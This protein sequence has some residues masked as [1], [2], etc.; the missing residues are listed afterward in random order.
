MTTVSTKNFNGIPLL[1]PNSVSFD[2][3]EFYV[4]YNNYDEYIYGC[5]TTAL[6]LGQMQHF[7]ILNGDHRKAY[8]ALTSQGFTACL[9]YF[10]NNSNL[11]NK[12]SESA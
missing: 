3:E 12:Y 1:I 8:E 9:E 2:S 7:Y 4:S 11:K 10:K 6:V 5:D